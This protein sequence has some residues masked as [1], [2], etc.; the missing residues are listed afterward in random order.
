[1]TTGQKK[2]LLLVHRIPYPPDKG[3][4]IR[5]WQLFQFLAKNFRLSAGFFVDDP[6]D[7]QHVSYL[8]GLC[9]D[10]KAVSLSPLPARLKSISGLLTGEPL[11]FPYYRSND[12]KKWVEQK[13]ALGVDL[14]VAFS[15]SMAPYIKNAI[16]PAFVD[17]VDADSAKWRDYA[18]GK[19]FPMSVIYRREAEKLAAAEAQ[20]TRDASATFLI[21]KAEAAVVEAHP[22]SDNDKIDWY[23]NGVDTEHFN[24]SIDFE[25]QLNGQYIVFT[26]AMDYEA[27]IDAATWFANTVWPAIHKAYP[28]LTFAIVGARPAPDIVKL[29]ARSGIIVTGRVPDIRP[30]LKGARL[31]VAPLRIARGVQNKVLEAMAM[32][33]PVVASEAAA[34]GIEA[35]PDEHLLVSNGALQMSA[36]IRK[37]LDCEE[38]CRQLG[39]SARELVSDIYGWDRQLA[40]FSQK[41]Q[42]FKLL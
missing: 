22:L 27:N 23:M 19:S 40:R 13:R 39:K 21:T 12:M 15:S 7:M 6:E 16:T 36:H 30:W 5:S 9:D 31:A 29:A 41:L 28:D 20:I 17:L 3:D 18:Q 10:I 24:P 8:A 25:R 14:E 1:M 26:G 34:Q 33:I 42:T 2:A 11:T 4:K 37:L 35:R 38:K 32:A